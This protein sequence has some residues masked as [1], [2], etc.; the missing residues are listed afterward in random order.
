M[1]LSGW[2]SLLPDLPVFLWLA[3][4][5]LIAGVIR[6]FTGFGGGLVMAPLFSL[7]LPPTDMV[8]VVILLNMVTSVQSLP[9]V[10]KDIDWRLVLSLSVP[11]MFGVPLGVWLV[12]WLEPSL[13]RRLIGIFVA[14]VSCIMLLGWQY[15]GKRGR[16]QNWFVGM[17]SGVLSAIAGVGGP[18]IVLYLISSK[19]VTPVMLR[20]FFMMYFTFAQIITMGF[21][22][23]QGTWSQTQFAYTLAF[24]PVLLVSTVIGSWLFHKTLQS[25]VALIKRL[26]LWFLFLVGCVTII[27]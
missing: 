4:A 20:A 25:N 7:V 24:L 23:A 2:Q 17:F 16:I 19:D 22:F 11:A 8:M 1:L 12:Q 21:Y 14:S 10:W 26:S 9:S 13:I 18:P 6:S 3:F 5:V 15:R 27:L